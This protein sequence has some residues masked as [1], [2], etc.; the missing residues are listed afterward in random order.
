[1]NTQDP[2]DLVFHDQHLT[3]LTA[4]I[5]TREPISV[6]LNKKNQKNKSN[7]PR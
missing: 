7:I 6:A 5:L 2:K 3:S 1:M 4:K